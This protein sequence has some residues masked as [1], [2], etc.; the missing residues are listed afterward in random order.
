MTDNSS[1]LEAKIS[2]DKA[3]LIEQLKSIPIVSVAC[4]KVGIGRSTYYRWKDEDKTFAMKAEDALRNG[5][6]M[7][8]DIASSQ[9]IRNIKENQPWAIMYWLKFNHPDFNPKRIETQPIYVETGLSEQ[10]LE[11]ID[12]NYE[13]NN[14][15]QK[16]EERALSL[17]QTKE[18]T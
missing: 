6:I 17:T 16:C 10:T 11:E 9:L 18:K 1:S 3:I 15:C 14:P 7:I 4:E 12:R 2:S 8:N 5:K 13:K